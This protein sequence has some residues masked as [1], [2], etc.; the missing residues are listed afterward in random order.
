MVIQHF[1]RKFDQFLKVIMV[2]GQIEIVIAQGNIIS[3]EQLMA[4]LQ[5][6]M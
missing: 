2:A 6:S 1:T 3:L 4:T 5:V